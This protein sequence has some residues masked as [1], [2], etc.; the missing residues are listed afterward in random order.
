MP[1]TEKLNTVN[2]LSLVIFILAIVIVIGANTTISF[3]D[4]IIK[5]IAETIDLNIAFPAVLFVLVSFISIF[6]GLIEHH[7][8]NK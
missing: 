2:L 1:I 4:V 8:S 7:I 6:E 3:D 5:L